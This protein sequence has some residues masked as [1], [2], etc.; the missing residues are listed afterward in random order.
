MWQLTVVSVVG[1]AYL[2][3]VTASRSAVEPE[4]SQCRP[5]RFLR[6]IAVCIALVVIACQTVPLLTEIELQQSRAAARQGHTA[7][8]SSRA[9][10]AAALE[11][12]AASPYL[13]IALIA[14]QR[15]NLRSARLFINRAIDR[16]LDDWRLWLVAAR[17]ENQTRCNHGRETEPQSRG[18][19]QSALSP[20][21]RPAS[22]AGRS[23]L[24]RKQDEEP[25][26]GG[27]IVPQGAGSCGTN[28]DLIRLQ[29][30]RGH[31]QRSPCA[32]PA[33]A[34]VFGSDSRS[35]ILVARCPSSPNAGACG[36]DLGSPSW[37]VAS[38]G[39]DR[40]HTRLLD[41]R[42]LSD[43]DRVSQ[44]ARSI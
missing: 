43:L 23:R 42:A 39:A 37:T 3:L 9:S 32:A 34:R 25:H 8:A 26:T 12:W 19:A 13:Q 1:A 29:A 30:E 4:P 7:E 11:P 14:E 17:I 21:R 6:A 24:G 5:D 40:H 44:A 22:D 41:R 28:G 20:L 33:R 31:A 15:R 35:V 27:R 2:G 10:A 36:R 16:N 38:R 18:T